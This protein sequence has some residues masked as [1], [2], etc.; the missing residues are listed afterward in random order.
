VIHFAAAAVAV[1][2]IL[3]SWCA[4][5]NTAFYEELKL[6]KSGEFHSWLHQRPDASGSWQLKGKTLTI[7]ESDDQTTV[8]TILSASKTRL[9]MR[10]EDEDKSETYVRPGHCLQF[11]SPPRE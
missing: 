11:E 9:V 10:E 1:S 7:H 5:S 2:T 6:D 3:G 8:Y 4:G